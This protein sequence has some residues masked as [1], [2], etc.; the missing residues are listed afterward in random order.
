MGV[1]LSKVYWPSMTVQREGQTGMDGITDGVTVGS[2]DGFTNK[3]RAIRALEQA[4][5]AAKP[6][7]KGQVVTQEGALLVQCHLDKDGRFV[8]DEL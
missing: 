4:V 5:R 6:L 3:R 8:W 1:R 2:G 7:T